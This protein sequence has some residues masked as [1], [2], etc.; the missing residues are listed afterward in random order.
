MTALNAAGFDTYGLEPSPTF[1]N[2]ALARGADP[3]R[4]IADQVETATFGRQF[5]LITF[6]AVLEHLQH[7][8][9]CIERALTW[10][11]PGG[12]IHIEVPT[13]RHLIAK[14]INGYNRLRGTRYV[15]HLSPMHPPYHLYEFGL[16]S[17]Q[18]HGRIAGYDVAH[19]RF[20]ENRV[21]MVPIPKLL[22]P[23]LEWMMKRF[24]RGMMLHVW[25]R[26]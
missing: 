18:A 15:T 25:L 2:A 21:L 5:D 13:S 22:H 26:A 17:F 7:P 10:L 6:G 19:H 20:D 23:P 11:K 8:A 1:R 14:I 12:L 3:K 16:K 4:L 9:A 24:D